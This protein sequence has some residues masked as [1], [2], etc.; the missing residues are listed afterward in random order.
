MSELCQRS[1]GVG[2]LTNVQKVIA[3]HQRSEGVYKEYNDIHL[4]Q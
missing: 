2:A 3:G 4:R 1:D